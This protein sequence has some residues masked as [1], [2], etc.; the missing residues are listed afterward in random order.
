[1]EEEWKEL[2]TIQRNAGPKVNNIFGINN[3]NPE[4]TVLISTHLISEIEQILDEVIFMHKGRA[5]LYTSVDNIREE[6]GKSV[7]GHFREVFAC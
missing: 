4:A 6:H 2:K 7:D 1:M 5:L 3:Y